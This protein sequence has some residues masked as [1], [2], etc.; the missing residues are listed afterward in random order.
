[1]AK[2]RFTKYPSGYIRASE[3]FPSDNIYRVDFYN[4]IGDL[5]PLMNLKKNLA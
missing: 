2:R 3:D 4:M 1:M 5:S